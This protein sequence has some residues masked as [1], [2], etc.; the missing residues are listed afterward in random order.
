MFYMLFKWVLQQS[1]VQQR[2]VG[3]ARAILGE[4][5]ADV[6]VNAP[7]QPV[8]VVDLLPSRRVPK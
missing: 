4:M 8:L 2:G 5:L 6:D 7:K 3:A 1:Q